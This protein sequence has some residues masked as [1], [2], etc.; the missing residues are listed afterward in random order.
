[1]TAKDRM[2]QHYMAEGNRISR[3]GYKTLPLPFDLSGLE[4]TFEEASFV[5]REW[6]TKGIPSAPDHADGSP[7]PFLKHAEIRLEE[8]ERALETSSSVIRWRETNP[9]KA[10]RDEDPIKLTL[11]R[12]KELVGG[13]ALIVSPSAVLLLMRRAG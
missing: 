2:L 7:G 4:G 9:E 3:S 8:L 13:E 10:W 1:M 5:R 6:D 11:G 12:V